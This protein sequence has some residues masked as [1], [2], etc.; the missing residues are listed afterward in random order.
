[1]S[2]TEGFQVYE[3]TEPYIFLSY[4]REHKDLMLKLFNQLTRAG[5]RVWCD[6]EIALSYKW[7]KVITKKTKECTHF[8]ALATKDYF[9]SFYCN[10]ELDEAIDSYIE[11]YESADNDSSLCAPIT[12]LFSNGVSLDTIPDDYKFVLKSFQHCFLDADETFDENSKVFKKILEIENLSKCKIDSAQLNE[13]KAPKENVPTPERAKAHIS[14]ENLPDMTP[15]M[16]SSALADRI[17]NAALTFSGADEKAGF[18]LYKAAFSARKSLV[19][20][21]PDNETENA[22]L[23]DLCSDIKDFACGHNIDAGE[24]FGA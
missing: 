15:Y 7:R 22:K 18:D 11:L 14:H 21:E 10:C 13:Q 1:M 24:I 4:K 23:S 5:Y 9:K 17:H 20:Q 12:I 8:I 3:G 2:E 16:V 19:D 6:Q